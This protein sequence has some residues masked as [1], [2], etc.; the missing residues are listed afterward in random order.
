MRDSVGSA[1]A[2][3]RRNSNPR[4]LVENRAT[5]AQALGEGARSM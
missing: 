3:P 5:P 1:P 2:R 4:D